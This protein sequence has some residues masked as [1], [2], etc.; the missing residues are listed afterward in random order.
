[1]ND[2]IKWRRGNKSKKHSN[3]VTAP[4]NRLAALASAALTLFISLRSPSGGSRQISPS[5]LEGGTGVLIDPFN[6]CGS[7]YDNH[8]PPFPTPSLS[9]P[10]CLFFV[11]VLIS[12]AGVS[13]PGS[14]SDGRCPTDVLRLSLDAEQF[15]S[16]LIGIHLRIADNQAEPWHTTQGLKTPN[17]KYL[18]PQKKTKN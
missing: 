5:V 2:I 15:V 10:R 7:N 16:R 6:W 14:H 8:W 13:C 12:G 1:M 9:S 18:V 11:C 3:E 4:P 17:S